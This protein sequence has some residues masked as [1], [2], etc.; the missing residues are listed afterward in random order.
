M[1]SF[2]VEM[3]AFMDGKIRTV[4]VPDDEY[5]EKTSID[6]ALNS[7]YHFGQNEVQ[8]KQMCSVSVKDVI[9]Y[10]GKRY[11]VAVTGFDEITD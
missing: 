7:I 8:P 10:K 4:D 9:R 1:T 2:E 6:G 5:I 11:R 3:H